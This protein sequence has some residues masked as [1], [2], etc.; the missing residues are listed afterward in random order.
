MIATKGIRKLINDATARGLR[1]EESEMRCIISTGKTSR[2]VGL[3]IYEDGTAFRSDVRLDLCM[4]IRSQ[5]DMRA[6]LGLRTAQRTK[7]R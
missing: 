4:T 2:A 6:I 7:R 5:R 3:V 1:V